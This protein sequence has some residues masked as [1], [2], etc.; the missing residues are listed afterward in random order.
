MLAA[1]RW[2]IDC[3]THFAMAFNYTTIK[4]LAIARIPFESKNPSHHLQKHFTRF[5]L[6]PNFDTKL[7]IHEFAY[8]AQA[9]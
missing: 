2:R 4:C 1:N 9:I 7:N 6:H 5:S 3:R 8:T